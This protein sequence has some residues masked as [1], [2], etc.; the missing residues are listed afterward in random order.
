VNHSYDISVTGNDMHCGVM[1]LLGSLLGHAF[2]SMT[3][4]K[5]VFPPNP[6]TRPLTSCTLFY[7][8]NE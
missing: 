7:Q 3:D 2:Q 6:L 1:E 5:S 8:R 4:L